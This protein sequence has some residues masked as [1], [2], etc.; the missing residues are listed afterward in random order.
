MPLHEFVS[1]LVSV[2]TR[3]PKT[4]RISEQDSLSHDLSGL[5]RIKTEYIQARKFK[6]D[7]VLFSVSELKSAQ[8]DFIVF[9]SVK[10]Y[11]T[12]FCHYPPS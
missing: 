1:P 3:F 7:C 6:V 9:E 4:A 8:E 11:K 2:D 5:G 10:N 12:K